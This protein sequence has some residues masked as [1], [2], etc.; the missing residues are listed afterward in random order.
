MK[1]ETGK[2]FVPHGDGLDYFVYDSK[3]KLIPEGFGHWAQ[4]KRKIQTKCNQLNKELAEDPN[5]RPCFAIPIEFLDKD[6][7]EIGAM[8]VAYEH[9]YGKGFDATKM[10]QLY[11]A[12][13]DLCKEIHLGKLNIRKDFSLIAAHAQAGKALFNAKTKSHDTKTS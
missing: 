10:E 6:G 2:R 4:A 7:N 9:T 11:T 3:L 5:G 13:Q 8:E 1:T 12:L